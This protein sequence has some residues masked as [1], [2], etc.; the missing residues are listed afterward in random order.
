M[1]YNSRVFLVFIG[2]YIG[3]LETIR[4]YISTLRSFIKLRESNDIDIVDEAG[5][6]VP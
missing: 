4:L 5:A 3:A 1:L 6:L 2:N